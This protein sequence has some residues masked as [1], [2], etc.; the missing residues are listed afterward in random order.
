LEPVDVAFARF[1]ELRAEIASYIDTV[2]TEADT[3]LKVI[4]PILLEVLLWPKRDILAEPATPSGFVDYSLGRD[5]RSRLIVE[6]KR[7]NRSLGCEG[8]QTKRGYK[9]SGGM[10]NESST[11]EGIGQAIRYCGEKNAE[12]ACVTN[13]REWI[14]F[15][16]N[17][18]GDGVDTR[19]GMAFVF[20]SLAAVEADFAFFYSLLSYEATAVNN[21][22]PYFQEA[23]GQPIRM[24]VFHKAIRP[25][26]TASYIAGSELSIDIDKL[27]STFFKRLTGDEDPDL[28]DACFVET[29]ESRLADTQLARIAHGLIDRVRDLESGSAAELTKL[30][31]RVTETRRHEFVVLIGTKGAGKS[32][33]VTRFFQKVLPPETSDRC[34]IIKIN[35]G[36]NPGDTPTVV[37][38]LDQTLL[39]EAERQIFDGDA[40]SLD[41]LT[42]VFYDEYTRLKK[43]PWQE[44]YKR[45]HSEFLIEFGK[46]LERIRSNRPHDYLQGLIR[47][48]VTNRKH[49]PV[50]VFD[51]TDHF[52]IHFQQ[53][54]Y[55]YARALYEHVICLVLL[56]ITDRTSWQLSKHGA[57]QSFD[58]E[59]FFLPTPPTASI[60][61]KR[62]EF[63]EA[64]VETAR[65]RPDDRYFLTRGIALSLR[66]LSAFARTLQNIFL[67]TSDIAD[68]VGDLANHDVR[69]TLELAGK[70]IASPHLQV[71]D[72]LKAYLVGTGLDLQKTHAQR[73]LICGHYDTYPAGLHDFVQNLFAL[74]EDLETTPLMGVR[75]LRILA[76]V[77]VTEHEGALIDVETLEAY[78]QGMNLEVRAVRLWLD[79]MLKAGLCLNFDPTVQE[80]DGAARLEISPAGR[81][82]LLWASA[83]FEYLGAMLQATPLLDEGTFHDLQYALKRKQWRTAVATFIDY[84]VKED[85]S[86]CS[87]PDHPAY[88][89]QRRIVPALE[90]IAER[91]RRPKS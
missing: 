60:I 21:F 66:D 79:V 55:Q 42:G 11:K 38:W 71:D 15:R 3:R 41:D 22:R 16:G 80:I 70:F 65:E 76:D 45:D 19:E 77:P 34:T 28:L 14:V 23:E 4:D 87:L 59:S 46:E 57:L 33:F 78:C 72:L 67:Q 39:R 9:L 43:G 90:S 64:R 73:A 81:Q 40:P 37:T 8:R 6:A 84:L 20:P 18:L 50:I 62:I 7:D 61:R 54:V 75:L 68:W 74:N 53:A 36:D 12:L 44:L 10:F 5:G 63:I 58:H 52:D 56:P 31:Q 2:S 35:L 85:R 27:M 25:I 88:D 30:I 91:L 32:T 26:G 49:I 17:R 51:N 24:S 48:V 13:G 83:E 47:H 29:A 89:S 86:Y 82:H 69:R 1:K